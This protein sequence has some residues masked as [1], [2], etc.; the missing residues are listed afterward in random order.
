MRLVSGGRIVKAMA[1][2]LRSDSPSFVPANVPRVDGELR[3]QDAQPQTFNETA[4]SERE[5]RF[6]AAKEKV[7][8]EHADLFR[9]LA[10]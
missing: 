6:Q 2:A 1:K 9:R 10:E 3:Q 5:R 4:L 7:F 8:R